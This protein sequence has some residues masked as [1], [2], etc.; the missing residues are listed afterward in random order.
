VTRF[1]RITFKRSDHLAKQGEGLAKRLGLDAE[2]GSG[3]LD[4]A[5]APRPTISRPTISF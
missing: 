5:A 2:R 3:S 4:R 1:G